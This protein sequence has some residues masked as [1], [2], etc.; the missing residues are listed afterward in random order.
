MAASRTDG[1]LTSTRPASAR[2]RDAR[3]SRL[4]AFVVSSALVVASTLLV[5][6]LT[7]HV[8]VRSAGVF[9][10]LAVLGASS[11][12]GLWWGLATSL[13]SA[14][15]FNFF[16]LPPAHTLV[17][18][19]SGDWLALAAFAV[20]AV[21]TSDLAAR[22][23]A[24]REEAAR[25]AEEASLGERL[26]TVIA[27][28]P[29]LD[30]AL[31]G[32]G[33]QAARTLGATTGVIVRGVSPSPRPGVLPLELNRRPIGELRLS[34]GAPGLVDSPA[35][36]RIARQLAGLIALGEERERRMREEVN[37][38]ALQRSDELKTALL[39]AVSHDLRS[40][41]QA[42][43]AAAGGLHFAAL[44]DEEQ[45][46]LD[47]IGAE[48]GRMSR[49]IE[50]LLDLSR[51]TA[52][53][54]RPAADWLD[55]RE[56]VEA[57]VAELFRGEPQGRVR[58]EPAPDLPLVH[59]DGPQLQRVVVNVLENALKFSPAD[60]PVDI[61]VTARGEVVE[62]AVSDHGPGVAAADAE[63]IFEP[64]SRGTRSGDVP[65]SGLGLAIARGLARSNGC[66]LRLAPRDGEGAT[67]VLTLP[68]TASGRAR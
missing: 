23:R 37:A 20:T 28:A 38:R 2:L 46:L 52:G 11:V 43:A 53:A 66:E 7:P 44:D 22:E 4:S 56:L 55:P 10:L 25:R 18:N 63:R 68:A 54:L 62:V 32:L 59:G 12:C 31:A 60:R 17:I 21:V 67:F 36:Q 9:Y 64:F 8:P 3:S 65:G 48:S 15:A 27:T 30:D 16:F 5:G 47:T 39:R 1:R 33:D 49:M 26:A 34:G 50:N 61:R 45:E 40:P 6:A 13:A 24:G 19:S 14:L 42:I 41:L 35:A 57:G 58:V 51:L 29:N